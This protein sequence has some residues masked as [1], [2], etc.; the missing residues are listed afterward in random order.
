MTLMS[1]ARPSSPGRLVSMT[2]DI[3]ATS[4]VATNM[5]ANHKQLHK[6]RDGKECLNQC[7][8][9]IMNFRGL[10]TGA[11]D[12]LYLDV[13][14]PVTEALETDRYCRKNEYQ[15]IAGWRRCV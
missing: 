13:W 15:V 6:S 5:Q 7:L 1:V 14:S 2:L 10:G 8:N 3:P 9:K 4:I 11:G 12:T